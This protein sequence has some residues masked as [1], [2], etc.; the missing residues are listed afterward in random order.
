MEW[1]LP[2]FAGIFLSDYLDWQICHPQGAALYAMVHLGEAPKNKQGQKL[3]LSD[4]I[5]VQ[6][7]GLKT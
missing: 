3:V 4:A 7:Q 5:A 2:I 6:S 1:A